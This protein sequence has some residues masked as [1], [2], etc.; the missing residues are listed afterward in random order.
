MGLNAVV[1]LMCLGASP[2]VPSAQITAAQDA[3]AMGDFDKALSILSQAE[4]A[5]ATKELKAESIVHQA[6]ILEA[7]GETV[8]ALIAFVRAATIL[9]QIDVNS[10]ELKAETIQLFR[11]GKALAREGYHGQKIRELFPESQDFSKCPVTLLN[12]Q[13]MKA[14][15]TTTAS[16][17]ITQ[18]PSA[19]AASTEAQSNIWL[20]SFVGAGL[21]SF[22]TGLALDVSLETGSDMKLEPIDFAGTGL[23]TVGATSALIG[24]LFNPY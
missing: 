14:P 3:F 15:A 4:M 8:D 20:W 18:E 11:C 1:L 22:A 23:M 24:L 7:M 21:A 17:A 5:A 10:V 12:D 9:P 6:V 13:Q 16:V 19:P 2:S